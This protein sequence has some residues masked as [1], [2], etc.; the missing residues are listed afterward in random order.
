MLVSACLSSPV[1]ANGAPAFTL[2]TER[3]VVLLGEPLYL[4]I[5]STSTMPPAL[6]E[7]TLSLSI[8]GPEGEVRDYR[9]PLRF[10][11]RPD[12][13]AVSNPSIAEPKSVTSV[14]LRFARVI[15]ADSGL[16]FRKPGRYRLQLLSPLSAGPSSPRIPLSD[17]LAIE[18]RMP[19]R[20]ADRRA[21]AILSRDP[22][23]YGLA[24]YLEGG[25]QFRSGMAIIREMAGFPNAYRRTARFV[26]A[27]DWSQD[28]T[29]YQGDASRP[30][31]LDTALVFADWDTAAGC[32]IPL[33]T[34]YRLRV[35]S[36]ILAFRDPVSALP[37]KVR[38]KLA[39][40]E[41]SLNP[42]DSVLLRSF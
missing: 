41:A 7:G 39:G 1:L 23:E 12:T 11:A 40:F 2:E 4:M 10:R 37:E 32:Y 34:A 38:R 28:Y 16:V 13:I 9:P 15:A 21:Y 36:G 19:R 8:Q 17:S 42:R 18:V 22:K 5:G 24:V 6:E 35:A 3:K 30:M 31:N 26:L 29:D 25:Q 33:R 27:S 20:Q 14:R